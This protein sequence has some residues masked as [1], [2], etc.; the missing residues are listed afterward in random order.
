MNTVYDLQLT[1]FAWEDTVSAT[2]AD[3]ALSPLGGYPEDSTAW[4]TAQAEEPSVHGSTG[5]IVPASNT[6]F[7]ARNAPLSKPPRAK[8]IPKADWERF[9]P[10]IEELYVAQDLKLSRVR[11]IMAENHGFVAA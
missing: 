11:E 2:T 10:I 1:D 6:P 4:S 9:R 3:A 7:A 8:I 5:T